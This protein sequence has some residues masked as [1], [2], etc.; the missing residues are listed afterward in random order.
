MLDGYGK[1]E[2]AVKVFPSTADFA[3]GEDAPEL[4]YRFF[5]PESGRYR[6]EFLT[7]P[8]NSAV[9]CRA[10]RMRV[11][12]SCGETKVLT[13]IPSDFHA[14]DHRDGRWCRGVLDQIRVTSAELSFE[15]GV[16]SLTIGALE[17]G[18][19]L[20]RIRIHRAS[21]ELPESYLGPELSSCIVK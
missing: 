9:N 18:A 11:E 4:T 10:M 17:A 14:G 7:A 19:V 12:T 1:Y 5:I 2:N 3:E 15:E 16:Q 21:S 6:V 8:T 20:E 13:L